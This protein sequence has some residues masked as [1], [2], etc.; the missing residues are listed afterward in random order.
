MNDND[1]FD[2]EEMHAELKE[3][4]GSREFCSDEIEEYYE[5]E[6]INIL[7]QLGLIKLV[8]H[9]GPAECPDMFAILK[10]I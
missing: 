3:R 5:F 1:D 7:M 4:F 8:K 10:V 2:F 6:K 9:D